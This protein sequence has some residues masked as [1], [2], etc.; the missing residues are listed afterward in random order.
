MGNRYQTIDFETWK[1]KDYCQIYRNAVQPQYCVSFELDVTN[2]KKR[3]KENNWS[4]TM[5]FIFAVTKC[6]NKIEEFRYRF[7]DGEVVLYES[8]DTSF[9]Y[10]DKETELFKV[11]NVPMQDTIEE[12]VQLATVTAEN[13]KESFTGP[14]ENDVYQFSALPWITFTHISHTDFGNRE[15]AQPIFDWGKYQE[16]EG[17][18]MMPFAVQV[19]HAFVDGIHIGKLADK[20]QRYLDEV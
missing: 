19:H 3:V 7:L 6:A 13:Q 11:V 5:A 2:F 15:K 4:F 17:K 14:V 10:L 20:L 1:R 18:F 8:I 12:F 9:T 16:R